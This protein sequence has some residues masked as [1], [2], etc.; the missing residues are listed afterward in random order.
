MSRPKGIPKTGGRQ[1]GSQ[2]KATAELK[3]WIGS[4]IDQNREQLEDDLMSLEPEQRWK[5]ISGLLG[6][7][8][9]KMQAMSAEVNLAQLPEEALDQITSEILNNLKND[10]NEG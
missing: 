7:V 9:P 5:V 8:T 4:L 3:E 1:K 6:Y 2:N 10:K